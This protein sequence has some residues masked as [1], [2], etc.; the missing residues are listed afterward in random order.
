MGTDN[1][2]QLDGKHILHTSWWERHYPVILA[3]IFFSQILVDAVN[4]ALQEIL[5]YHS[6]LPSLY[7]IG[8]FLFLLCFLCIGNIGGRLFILLSILTPLLFFMWSLNH[9]PLSLK[10]E[11][12]VLTRVLYPYLMLNFV[13]RFKHLIHGKT[14]LKILSL[15]G[16]TAGFLVSLCAIFNISGSSAMVAGF[17]TKGIFRAGND[18]GLTILLSFIILIYFFALQRRWGLIFLGI[19]MVYGL[20]NLGTMT[21]LLGTFCVCI[22]SFFAAIFHQFK[23][24]QIP[25]R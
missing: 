18:I 21:G 7:K 15:Y 5:N 17:G 1:S 12:T 9:E 23:D 16:I 3:L 19:C 8:L 24:I 4:G 14:L 25:L 11:L 10:E 13:L 6:F 2:I 22:V 20:F